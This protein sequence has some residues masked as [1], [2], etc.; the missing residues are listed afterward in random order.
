MATQCIH[1]NANRVSLCMERPVNVTGAKGAKRDDVCGVKP[2]GGFHHC[3]MNTLI[4]V[5]P[6][7]FN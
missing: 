3:Q 4:R 6:D 7:H 2:V 1:K 5:S